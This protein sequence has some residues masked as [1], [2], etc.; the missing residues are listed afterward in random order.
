MY[1]ERMHLEKLN[2]HI[3]LLKS[4]SLFFFVNFIENYNRSL[5][6]DDSVFSQTSDKSTEDESSSDKD[7][8]RFLSF[9]MI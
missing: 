2:K 8:N 1:N 6:D 5:L 9:L 3:Y 4:K 7:R